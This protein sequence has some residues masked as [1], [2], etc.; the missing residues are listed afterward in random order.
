MAKSN[1]SYTS[2]NT[3]ATCGQKYKLRYRDNLRSKYFHAAL[4]FGS[5]I[6]ASL[7]MLLTTKD[8]D[9]ANKEFD[10]S[11]NFQWVNKKY[12]SVPKYTEIVYAEADYDAELL[13]ENDFIKLEALRYELSTPTLNYENILQ[14]KKKIG[15]DNL[16]VEKKQV[17]NYSNWLSLRHKGLIMLESYSKKILPRIKEVLAVQKETFLENDAGDKIVQYLDLIV[18]WEDGRN[19]L[20]DNK[21]SSRDYDNDQ[22]ARSPQLISYYSGAKA[23]YKLDSVGF[24]VLKKN[25]NKNKIKICSSCG[26]DGSRNKNRTCNNTIGKKRCN[27]PWKITIDPECYMQVIINDVT[28]TAENLVLDS[29]HEANEGIKKEHFYKNLSACKSG[30]IVCEFYNLC[31]FGNRD[32]VVDITKLKND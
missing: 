29:F 31:W 17:F 30:P 6:D 2:I 19:I 32:E 24:I 12:V 7:N 26:F 27:A 21:T 5:A 25:I 16:S 18:T 14:E 4:A 13:D 9:K 11:W 10:K 1:L 23:Q 22:A 15:W 3:Y 20:F 8:L 28:A